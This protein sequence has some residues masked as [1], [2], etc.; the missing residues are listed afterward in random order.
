MLLIDAFRLRLA[1]VARHEVALLVTGVDLAR[2]VDLRVHLEL[3]AV[4]GDPA[5]ETADG[6]QDGEEVRREAHGAARGS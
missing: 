6:E 2:A 5:R 1:L 3:L 4:L